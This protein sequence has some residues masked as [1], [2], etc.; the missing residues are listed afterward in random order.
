MALLV[1]GSRC[2]HPALRSVPRLV[3]LKYPVS[4]FDQ[5]IFG[6]IM[7]RGAADNFVPTHRRD[8]RAGSFYRDVFRAEDFTDSDWHPCHDRFSHDR[9]VSGFA[10]AVTLYTV[11]ECDFDISNR[12]DQRRELVRLEARLVIGSGEVLIHR[13]VL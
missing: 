3:N 7:G 5:V 6:K 9:S 4:Q 8:T 2:A 10:P 13:E 11:A 12:S 1:P